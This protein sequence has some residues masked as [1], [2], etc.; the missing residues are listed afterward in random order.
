MSAE[1]KM[2][3]RDSLDA[4]YVSRDIMQLYNDFLSQTD[5]RTLDTYITGIDPE[6]G[7]TRQQTIQKLLNEIFA[8]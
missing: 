1:E 4:M 5:R 2:Y 7:L 6:T 3:I 8:D